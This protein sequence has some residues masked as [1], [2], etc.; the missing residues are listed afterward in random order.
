MIKNV[1]FKKKFQKSQK[2]YK[3]AMHNLNKIS[4]NEHDNIYNI[5]IK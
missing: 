2:I 4:Y 3:F 1:L 5:N